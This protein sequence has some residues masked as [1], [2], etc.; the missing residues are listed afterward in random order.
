VDNARNGADCVQVRPPLVVA[1]T[2]VVLTE[3]LLSWAAPVTAR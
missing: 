2:T 1:K 3:L